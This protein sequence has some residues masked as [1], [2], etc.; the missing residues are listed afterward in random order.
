MVPPLLPTQ[1][2][3]IGG[4]SHLGDVMFNGTYDRAARA[5]RNRTVAAEYNRLFKATKDPYLAPY[6][7]RIAKDHLVR[8][9]DDLRA[10]ER[11][12]LASAADAPSLQP[13]SAAA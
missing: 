1:K 2:L 11:E 10:V 4:R 13:R 8:S 3:P 9:Q 7:L 6:Y 12:N 5:E